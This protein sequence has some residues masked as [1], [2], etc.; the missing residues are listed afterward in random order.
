M[1]SSKKSEKE[2]V[3]LRGVTVR[4]AGDREEEFAAAC[5]SDRR[6]IS[7]PFPRPTSGT[8]HRFWI[9]QGPKL[10]TPP[11]RREPINPAIP[12]GERLV[13]AAAISARAREETERYLQPLLEEAASAAAAPRQESPP[14]KIDDVYDLAKWSRRYSRWN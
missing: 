6:K 3:V 13:R 7:R 10:P 14:R 9:E 5:R 12:D 2:V 4:P 11:P 1:S 8:P